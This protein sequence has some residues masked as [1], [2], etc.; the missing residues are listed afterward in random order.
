MQ[1]FLHRVP[2]PQSDR[3]NSLYLKGGKGFNLS[4]WTKFQTLLDLRLQISFMKRLT[5]DSPGKPPSADS[6][7]PARPL[8]AACPVRNSKITHLIPLNGTDSLAKLRRPGGNP[9]CES[10]SR[11]LPSRFRLPF[12]PGFCPLSLSAST[13]QAPRF[14][15]RSVTFWSGLLDYFG[16]LVNVGKICA[17]IRQ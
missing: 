17:E 13:D 12:C 1:R 2:L 14:E 9:C 6:L 16:V 11:F 10:S 15:A 8:N 7:Q 3:G 5:T 4:I